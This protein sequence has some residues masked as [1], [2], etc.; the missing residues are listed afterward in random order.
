VI[1]A[2]LAIHLAVASPRAVAVRAEAVAPE[3]TFTGACYQLNVYGKLYGV[4]QPTVIWANE[5]S[6][7][8]SGTFTTS[9]ATGELLTH[10]WPFFMPPGT[11]MGF[12]TT[13]PYVRVDLFLSDGATQ[14]FVWGCP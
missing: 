10:R 9:S 5:T 8:I 12:S 2:L 4:N 7:P 1:A 3:V 6:V 14:S 11:Q 13:A